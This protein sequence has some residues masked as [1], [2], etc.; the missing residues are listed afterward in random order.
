MPFFSILKRSQVHCIASS[1]YSRDA[2]VCADMPD[3]LSSMI[4][5]HVHQGPQAAFWSALLGLPRHD[6]NCT[7]RNSGVVRTGPGSYS[8]CSCGPSSFMVNSTLFSFAWFCTQSKNL[9]SRLA[10]M[11]LLD[12]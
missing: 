10:L 8:D 4:A 11:V 6:V 3:S 1:L 5:M 7:V 2:W 12:G 9:L